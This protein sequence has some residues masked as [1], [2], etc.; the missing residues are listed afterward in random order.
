[1]S[2]EIPQLE[3]DRLLLREFREDDFEAMAAFY[4]DPVSNYYGGP[5]ERDEAWRKFA[6]FSGHWALRGFGPWA[7]EV[8]STRTFV[9]LAG[10]WFPEGWLE[11][12]ITWALVPG[13]HGFGY[14]SE[15]AQRSLRA[16][17]EDYGWKTAISI[18]AKSNSAS[19]RVAERL[20]A[21]VESEV[22]FRDVLSCVFRHKEPS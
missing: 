21:S 18:V 19:V 20:G 16:G 10:L 12:E 7:I 1:M 15:A 9:G 5:C 17:Y 2:V 11:P 6:V 4:A 3:T 13:H 14:A 22:E 8:K